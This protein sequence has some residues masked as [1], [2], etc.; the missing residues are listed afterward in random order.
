MRSFWKNTLILILALLAVCASVSCGNKTAG[1]ETVGNLTFYDLGD[2]TYGVGVAADKTKSV[3]A[4]E[5]PVIHRE[6][7]VVKIVREGFADCERLT[8]VV[9]PDGITVI[10]A[11]AFSNCYSLSALTLNNTLT[12]VG[13]YA[14][15]GCASLEGVVL[16]NTV[17]EVGA[18]AFSFCGKLKSII[19][20]EN[21]TALK[22]HTFYKCA[23]LET[24]A[25]PNSIKSIGK[26]ALMDCSALS[27]VS[28]GN[29][30]ETIE[31]NAL[32]GCSSMT[33]ITVSEE[34]RSYR[35][36][37]GILYNRPTTEILYIPARLTGNIVIPDG[38]N[39]IDSSAFANQSGITSLTVP[40]S[41][42]S[43]GGSAFAGCTALESVTFAE[44]KGWKSENIAINAASLQDPA[45]AA[46]F[47]TEQYSYE[48]WKRS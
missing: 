24:V 40:Q 42:A 31:M 18:Y 39:S 29:G 23:S 8:T 34:N 22:P 21:Q 47:L 9:I 17:T 35:A 5:I 13:D 28:I 6:R 20:S 7:P 45:T 2:G 14:F 41:V 25:V 48:A 37:C 3:T 12:T 19:L 38:V 26:Y 16:P 46:H 10:D 43:I 32:N 15:S 44:P 27:S 11:F 4:V 33:S 1:A 30:L 36:V